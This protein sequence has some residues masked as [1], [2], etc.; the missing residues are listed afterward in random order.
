MKLCCYVEEPAAGSFS[1]RELHGN[2]KNRGSF[3]FNT[4]AG[5]SVSISQ[6]APHSADGIAKVALRAR[7]HDEG[8][9]GLEICTSQLGALHTDPQ[10]RL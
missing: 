5:K 9:E 10:Q 6:T 7:P 2:P 3:L 4:T 8:F 1:V